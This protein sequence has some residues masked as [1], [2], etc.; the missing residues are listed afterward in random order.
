VVLPKTHQS[1]STH[2]GSSTA[3]LG[4]AAPLSFTEANSGSD[5]SKTNSRVACPSVLVKRHFNWVEDCLDS[6]GET[7]WLHHGSIIP[8]RELS[9]VTER[10]VRVTLAAE[11][12]G[13]CG[14]LIQTRSSGSLGV[15]L[16]L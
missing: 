4:K 7:R 9:T 5:T 6:G 16:H 1:S 13:A 11:Q 2:R 12:S 10:R 8:S 14:M 15:R 3:S